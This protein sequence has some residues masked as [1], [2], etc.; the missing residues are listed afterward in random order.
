MPKTKIAVTLDASLL[1]EVDALVRSHHFTN[2]SQA[3]E[4]AVAEQLLRFRRTRLAD[5]CARLD[6]AEE[7]ALAEEGF[8]ADVAVWPEY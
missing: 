6:P 1:T 8:A 5:A 3:I 4:A 2:R 7:R